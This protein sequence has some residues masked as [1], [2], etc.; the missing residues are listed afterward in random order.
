MIYLVDDSKYVL[1]YQDLKDRYNQVIKLN[2]SQFKQQLPMILHLA[3]M[4]CY[5]KEIPA[6]VCLSDKGII[7]ELIHMLHIPEEPLVDTIG[8]MQLFK[9]QLQLA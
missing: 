8:I 1:S 2:E 3:C 7:H 4:I 6:S 9:D 5:L